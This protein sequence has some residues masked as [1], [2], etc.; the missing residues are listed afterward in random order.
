MLLDLEEIMEKS[1]GEK[2]V[3]VS[4]EAEEILFNRTA[5]PIDRKQPFILRLKNVEERQLLIN[6]ETEVGVILICDRCLKEVPKT[7][8]VTIKKAFTLSEGKIVSDPDWDEGLIEEGH[9]LCIDRLVSEEI[10]LDFPT[11]ILCKEDCKGICTVCGQDLNVRDCGCDRTVMD[12]RMAKFS[13][14]FNGFKE[15]E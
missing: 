4:F 9:L 13:E 7:F 8:S 6:G 5:Y 2:E 3:T 14:I 1:G 15:V 11:K 12:P 10:L